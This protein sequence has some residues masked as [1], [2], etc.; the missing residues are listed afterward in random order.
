MDKLW[1]EEGEEQRQGNQ[2]ITRHKKTLMFLWYM[3]NQNSFREV[4]D[5]FDVSQSRAHD[6]ILEILDKVCGLAK[7]Y[8]KW[9]GACDKQTSSGVFRRL[10]GLDQVIG[11]IDGCHIRTLKP[12]DRHYVSYINR[13]G[14][15]S[16]L[17]QGICDDTGRFI[18][19]FAG[20]PGCVHDARLL[21][22]S[23]FYDKHEELMAGHYLLGDSAYIANE[24]Q[25]FILV[26]KRDNGRLTQEEARNNT[27]LSRG[28][29]VIENAFGRL[30]CRFRRVRDLQNTRLDVS[31]KIIL[32]A[33]TLH[34]FCMGDQ[35]CEDHPN[36][37]PRELDDNEDEDFQI[38]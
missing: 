7:D 8:I 30:K 2:Q 24:F 29:V 11:A 13:K 36:G 31:V 5:K 12:N 3:G 21:R 14:Y 20:P 35:V 9:P 10:T 16:I 22:L 28:R 6:I 38:L 37:C 34:N 26:P 32:A 1:Q 19:V 4:S 17:L 33:C 23:D 15:Y 18:D 27:L 25:D